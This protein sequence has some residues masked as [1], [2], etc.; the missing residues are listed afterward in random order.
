MAKKAFDMNR[1]KVARELYE[2]GY[3][4]EKVISQ[5][6]KMGDVNIRPDQPEYTAK[7]VAS[8]EFPKIYP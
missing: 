7:R 1:T 8:K 4:V 6:K 5:M 2:K 3:S